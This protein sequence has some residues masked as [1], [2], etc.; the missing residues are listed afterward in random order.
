MSKDLLNFYV[1]NVDAWCYSIK[2]LFPSKLN[3]ITLVNKIYNI[4]YKRYQQIQTKYPIYSS[5]KEIQNEQK[6]IIIISFSKYIHLNEI[7]NIFFIK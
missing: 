6:K 4:K 3:D 7:T 5:I 1:S 2:H